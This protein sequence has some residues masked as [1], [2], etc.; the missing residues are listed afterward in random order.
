MMMTIFKEELI[1][2]W[3]G[4]LENVR[5]YCRKVVF[6]SYDGIACN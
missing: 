3:L 4:E 5:R 1:L 2:M 6:D